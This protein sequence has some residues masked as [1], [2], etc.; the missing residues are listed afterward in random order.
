M[1]RQQGAVFFLHFI[2]FYDHIFQREQTPLDQNAGILQLFVIPLQVAIGNHYSL[3]YMRTQIVRAASRIAFS[4]HVILSIN[5][6]YEATEKNKGLV[7]MIPMGKV[8]R[9][10]FK[11]RITD[12]FQALFFER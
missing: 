6:A 8:D 9:Q 7:F 10:N 5:A 2:E 12:N 1:N 3:G 11:G 4:E